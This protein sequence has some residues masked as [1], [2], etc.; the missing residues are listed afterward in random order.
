MAR[1]SI[2]IFRDVRIW[3]SLTSTEQR[4]LSPAV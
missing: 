4:L 3:A 1:V 2:F